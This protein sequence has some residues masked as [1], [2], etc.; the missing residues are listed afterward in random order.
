MG[1]IAIHVAVAAFVF[2]CLS[3]SAVAAGTATDGDVDYSTDAA[4][5]APGG[6]N[7]TKPQAPA[8]SKAL[9]EPAPSLSISIED[10]ERAATPRDATSKAAAAPEE[11]MLTPLGEHRLPR[12]TA[13][14]PAMTPRPQVSDASPGNRLSP[15]LAMLES[16]LRSRF[17]QTVAIK[18][19]LPKKVI[20][21]PADK[22]V[23]NKQSRLGNEL[24]NK[25][26]NPAAALR[27]YEAAYAYDPSNS[28]IAGSYGYTLFR[29]GL[30]TQARDKTIESLEISPGYGAAWF[31]LGQIYGYL[32]LEEYAYASFVNTCLF[33]KNIHTTLGFLERERDKYGEE[34]V[35]KAAGRALATCQ[36]LD[37]ENLSDAGA[38]ASPP[39]A[40]SASANLGAGNPRIGM[41]DLLKVVHG[42]RM[43]SGVVAEVERATNI[44]EKQRKA[45][46]EER[47]EPFLKAI[48]GTASLYAR[49]HGYK[50]ILLTAE[51]KAFRQNDQLTKAEFP[52]L[53]VDEA[54]LAFLNSSVGQLFR[55]QTD[56]A[57]LTQVIIEQANIP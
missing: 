27:A 19:G 18:R 7:P 47:I 44:S 4:G 46:L 30:F 39:P 29:N 16:T 32:K 15:V 31:V 34:I 13:P 23:S 12:P 40:T 11:P 56:I 38:P 50:I 43:L 36:K 21:A 41:I 49:T 9:E 3:V 57:D 22:A 20:N 17:S 51:E 5:A 2:A 14:P 33:T 55:K 6:G 10:F 25:Q 54:L 53:E 26:D 35:Q 52:L 42:S 24:L 48:K 45:L 8:A 1:K 37:V 28:E